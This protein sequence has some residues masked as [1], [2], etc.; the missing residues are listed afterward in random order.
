[1]DMS[2]MI[3]AEE[4]VDTKS[5]S[6]RMKH[7]NLNTPCIVN[8]KYV[9]K[10]K[11]RAYSPVYRKALAEFTNPTLPSGHEY[12]ACHACNNGECIN[13]EHIYWGTP[14]ENSDDLVKYYNE[15]GDWKAK[16]W[17]TKR[18]I[19]KACR[20]REYDEDVKKGRIRERKINN[21]FLKNRLSANIC[22]TI[23]IEIPEGKKYFHAY[24]T[25]KVNPHKLA[26]PK[27]IK[28]N[29]LR[30]KDEFHRAAVSSVSLYFANH[31]QKKR[32]W[33]PTDI[34]EDW[35]RL[36]DNG[37]ITSKDDLHGLYD[38]WRPN[39]LVIYPSIYEKTC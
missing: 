29:L 15:I 8:E 12:H 34:I 24:Y 13:P 36:W 31:H 27:N 3:C 26:K 6:Y 10:T 32:E 7:V 9:D 30:E 25:I 11:D 23:R 22:D 39:N 20:L 35:L 38:K 14:K 33:V 28:S 21:P 16:K 17:I 18:D 37:E 4:L 1:M 19:M 5:R 2:E